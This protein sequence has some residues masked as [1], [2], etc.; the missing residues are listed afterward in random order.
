MKILTILLS[1]IDIKRDAMLILGLLLHET[2]HTHYINQVYLIAFQFIDCSMFDSVSNFP[3]SI[4]HCISGAIK[5]I[6]MSSENL[7]IPF[8]PGLWLKGKQR[9]GK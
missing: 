8:T 7:A 9:R 4:S 1:L 6:N 2:H 3:G 5:S